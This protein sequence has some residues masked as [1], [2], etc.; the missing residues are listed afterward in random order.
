M[1]PI[2]I[3]LTSEGELV[4][5]LRELL[6]ELDAIT[7]ARS[8]VRRKLANLRGSLGQQAAAFWLIEETKGLEAKLQQRRHQAA[9]IPPDMSIDSPEYLA[10]IG[11]GP[12]IAGDAPVDFAEQETGAYRRMSENANKQLA[13]APS[14][15]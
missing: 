5:P 1:T 12:G 6:A 9:A 8:H 13:S 7:P 3:Y 15:E 10:S 2:P 4:V 11:E 14:P